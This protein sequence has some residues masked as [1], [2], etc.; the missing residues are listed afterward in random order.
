MSIHL[1]IFYN[2]Q[3]VRD[4]QIGLQRV[5]MVQLIFVNAPP[6][7]VRNYLSYNEYTISGCLQD[8]DCS[9][10]TVDEHFYT[11]TKVLHH[12]S[13]PRNDQRQALSM[14]TSDRRSHIYTYH[15]NQNS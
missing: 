6:H 13:L 9:N 2:A 10:D 5:Y 11:Q 12:G 15:D 4:I 1:G 3:L 7:P 8:N 14:G